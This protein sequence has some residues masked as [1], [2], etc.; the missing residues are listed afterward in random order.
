[1]AQKTNTELIVLN[2]TKFGENSIVVHTLSRAYGRRSFLVRVGKKAAMSLF[3]PL[4]LLE[5]D[6]VENPRAT[7][8]NAVSPSVRHPLGGLRGSL[9]K[10][11]MAVF[12]SE[13]LYRVIRDGEQDEPLF[14]WCVRQILTLDALE[15]DFSNFHLLFLLG[16]AGAL[17]F[18]PTAVELS[19]F[20]R[21][22]PGEIRRLVES[23]P[24]VA[25]LLP[26]TGEIRSDICED[27]LHYL[28]FHTDA[29]IEIR[30]LD[31]L[32]ELFA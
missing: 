27:L 11:A 12:M 32:R 9:Y 19:P 29:R 30:S 22:H 31:V 7:L 5:A 23:D 13:V 4:S 16:L 24:D 1:M 10:G 18:S 8:W 26:L 17:G 2:Y 6:I 3:Q 28:E 15:S 25:L 21:R 14:D 20:A